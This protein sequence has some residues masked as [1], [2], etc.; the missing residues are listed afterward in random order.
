MKKNNFYEVLLMFFLVG[1]EMFPNGSIASK[2]LKLFFVFMTLVVNVLYKKFYWTKYF[3]WV[4][5]M[6]GIAIIS[7]Q[8]AYSRTIA[9]DGIKTVLL[10]SICLLSFFQLICFQDN[11]KKV[12]YQAFAIG[13][14]M[15]LFYLLCIYKGE[16][17]NG[18]RNIGIETGYNYVGMIAGLGV[19]FSI[20][21]MVNDKV[22]KINN[23]S[24]GVLGIINIVIVILSMS[25]KAISYFLIP[26]AIYYIF[27]DK[28]TL[29]RLKNI[30][31]LLILTY[32][33]YFLILKI[34]FLYHLVGS[35]LEELL[36]FWKNSTGDDSAAGRKTRILWGLSWF[37]KKPLIGYGVMNF[38]YLFGSVEKTSDMVVADN[39]YIELLVSY[40]II[41]FILYYSLFFKTIVV[42]LFS[43]N[44]FNSEKILA[45]GMLVSLLIGD[46]GSSSYIYLQNQI[47]L[48]I[49]VLL[50]YDGSKYTR[51]KIF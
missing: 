21:G 33:G 50:L 18:L 29:K 15:R 16:I 17:F 5:M 8:W 6:G 46:Y 4:L 1:M 25:R 47:F 37:Y 32:F 26:L 51:L 13:P 28:D 10:N 24:W 9:M 41:G 27:S 38:N 39:N 12:V 7:Y 34:P 22:S 43:I 40:G 35:G 11:W 42:S 14:C 36:G 20:L 44:N 3:N 30:F 31:V 45:F 2:L 19:I 49:S 48:M 23:P